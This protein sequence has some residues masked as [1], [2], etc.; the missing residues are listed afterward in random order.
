MDC[1]VM[2]MPVV[3]TASVTVRGEYEEGTMT[4]L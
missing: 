1:L 2:K 3:L 4:D